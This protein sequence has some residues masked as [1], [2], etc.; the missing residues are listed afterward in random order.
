MVR[1]MFTQRT[2]FYYDPQRQGYDTSQ[3]RTVY[4]SPVVIGGSLMLQQASIIHYGDILRG[5]V[6]FR[7]AVPNSPA[8]GEA[9]TWG[10]YNLGS[11]AYVAFNIAGEVFSAIVSNGTDSASST[12]D[13]QS[14]WAGVEVEYRI[15]WEA[16]TAKFYVN[17]VRQAAITNVAVYGKP[18]SLYVTNENS[19]QM[20]VGNIAVAAHSFYLHEALEDSSTE[21]LAYIV[22][23]VSLAESVTLEVGQFVSSSEAV[24]IAESRTFDLSKLPGALSEA[25]SITESQGF[26]LLV[27]P[28]L[29]S[30]SVSIAEDVA[31][32][33]TLGQ[34][35]FDAVSLAESMTSEV[36]TKVSA[37]DTALVSED[38]TLSVT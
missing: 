19:D 34:D 6:N 16:G 28:A 2:N 25:V 8:G 3:W 5:E 9:R 26:E 22:Q 10:L 38:I 12:I 4:G 23:I 17:G 1:L 7:V 24:S 15:V 11:G 32:E 29:V 20:S 18:L 37:S 27:Y 36:E 13:W 33:W 31:T 14:S 21:P 30:D 35:S